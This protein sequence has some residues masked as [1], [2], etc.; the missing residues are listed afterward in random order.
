[1]EEGSES[2]G[3]GG[4][5]HA[6]GGR[7]CAKSFSFSTLTKKDYEN[8]YENESDWETSL[9]GGRVRKYIC[10]LSGAVLRWRAS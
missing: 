6:P 1:M 10:A 3:G 2:R 7:V 9:P 4:R 5:K 8:E